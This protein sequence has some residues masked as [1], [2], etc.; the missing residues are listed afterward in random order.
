MLNQQPIQIIPSEDGTRAEAGG[1]IAEIRWNDADPSES[2]IV[3]WDEKSKTLMEIP[4]KPYPLIQQ[5]EREYSFRL[6][7]IRRQRIGSDLRS[8]GNFIGDFGQQPQESFEEISLTLPKSLSIQNYR[9]LGIFQ[10]GFARYAASSGTY[11]FLALNDAIR[12]YIKEIRSQP[13]RDQEMNQLADELLRMAIA[14]AQGKIQH[15]ECACLQQILGPRELE[16][17]LFFKGDAPAKA[18]GHAFLKNQSVNDLSVRDMADY[19]EHFDRLQALLNNDSYW[20]RSVDEIPEGTNHRTAVD[21]FKARS[22]QK[23]HEA[24]GLFY[25]IWVPG[26]SLREGILPGT[27][28]VPALRLYLDDQPVGSVTA[29][30]GNPDRGVE[31]YITIHTRQ[32]E[33]NFRTRDLYFPPA[34]QVPS[35]S[36]LSDSPFVATAA[37]SVTWAEVTRFIGQSRQAGLDDAAIFNQ[38]VLDDRLGGA[39]PMSVLEIERLVL[40]AKS[41][42]PG[43]EN[44]IVVRQ[45]GK[46]RLTRA[47]EAFATRDESKKTAG[48]AAELAANVATCDQFAGFLRFRGIPYGSEEALSDA[49]DSIVDL[50]GYR[51]SVFVPLLEHLI[52]LLVTMHRKGIDPEKTLR[53]GLPA[54]ARIAGNRKWVFIEAM[55]LA[56][57]LVEKGID[58]TMA[59]QWG[60]LSRIDQVA[61]NRKK[62]FRDLQGNLE[63]LI[64]AMDRAGIHPASTLNIGLGASAETARDRKWVLEEALKLA[65]R[66]ADLGINP[67]MALQHGVQI[68]IQMAGN[69][70]RVYKNLLINLQEWLIAMH[71]KGIDPRKTLKDGLPAVVSAAGRR[72]WVL[73]GALNLSVTLAD[74][75]IDTL[76][77]LQYGLRPVAEVAGNRQHVFNDLLGYLQK[78]LIA[79]HGKGFDPDRILKSGLPTI[80]EI[81]GK[82]DWILRKTLELA[83]TLADKGIN[84][85][86]TLLHFLPPEL[87][88]EREWYVKGA[89]KLAAALANVGMDPDQALLWGPSTVA[90]VA[91]DSEEVFNDLLGDL[92]ECLAA[93]H[94]KGFDPDNILASSLPRIADAVGNRHRISK[95]AL[96]LA[97]TLTHQGTDPSMAFR[98]YISQFA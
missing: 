9:L 81:A 19:V 35:A 56:A 90:E 68:I 43:F 4:L 80:A 39:R 2:R 49:F 52:E 47:T 60:G 8:G 84:P 34:A 50:A 78:Y 66:L 32:M 63:L 95:E 25:S 18:H 72:V 70:K 30:P 74:N 77:A 16:L 10:S 37:Q 38:F 21:A 23:Y 85:D 54:A 13:N 57:R 44:I 27:S 42:T 79:M 71:N 3:I 14:L 89:L 31:P 45:D 88:N 61:R 48:P 46:F 87:E 64:I 36:Q 28:G 5:M 7:D 93:M 82:R 97:V 40:S 98:N 55:G 94:G 91:G 12:A 58:P 29:Y 51:N 62:V 75:G 11:E 1:R 86:D 24:I 53:W 41:E 33:L 73:Q 17:T 15:V 76:M 6:P 67:V 92:E 69:R 22:P 59:L 96:M 26:L 65:T 83:A 20:L